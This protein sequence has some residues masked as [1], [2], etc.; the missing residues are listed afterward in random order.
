[1]SYEAGG[2]D[3]DLTGLGIVAVVAV[4]ALALKAAKD[5]NQADD[6]GR[7]RQRGS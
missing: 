4:G 3:F 6:S 1:M 5:A 2:V 7:N